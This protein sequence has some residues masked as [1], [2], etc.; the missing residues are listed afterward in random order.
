M[1]ILSILR[2]LKFVGFLAIS[3]VLIGGLVYLNLRLISTEKSLSDIKSSQTNLRENF[4]DALFEDHLKVTNAMI[5]EASFTSLQKELETIKAKETSDEKTIKDVYDALLILEQ[6]INRNVKAGLKSPDLT[7]QKD[8]WGDFLM[9]KDFASIMTGINEQ[10][11][12]LDKDY[13][14]YL[15]KL[16]QTR[17]AASGYSYQ[18][19]QTERG[20]FGAHIIKLPLNEVKV[21]TVSASSGSCSNDCDTKSLAGYVKDSGGFAGMNGSYFCPPDYGSCDGKINSFDFAL[22]DSDEGKWEHK[23]ALTWFDTG[24]MT[25]NGGSPSFYRKTSDYGGG[26]VTAG[27]SNYPSLVKDGDIVVDGDKLTSYQKDIKGTRGVI[28]VGGENLYLAIVNSATVIDAAYVIR[29]LGAKHA[30]NLDGGG[31]SAMYING[32]YIVGP[33]RSLPNAIVLTK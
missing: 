2:K 25:F 10:T 13:S 16:E 3:L 7:E 1:K 21:K 27:I 32:K 11:T 12:A 22:Y 20:S 14:A 4:S 29:S 8:A 6:K 24:L 26:G 31:S 5:A 28:G 18:T 9:K 33:G 23:D 15:A 17:V 19:V 30:L